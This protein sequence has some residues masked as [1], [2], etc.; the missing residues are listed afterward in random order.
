ML[1]WICKQAYNLFSRQPIRLAIVRRYQDANGNYV[2][3]LYMEQDISRKHDTLT[4]YT[5]I[6][7]S[8]DTL[9]IFADR[10]DAFH[11]SEFD[12]TL[13]TRNDFLAPMMSNVVRV[14]SLDPLANDSVRRMIA[15]L[16]RRNI[17]MTVQNKFIED[18]RPAGPLAFNLQTKTPEQIIQE[19]DKPC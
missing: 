5:M 4:G 15:R 8:L 10:L 6:G 9:P 2:G 14:G 19:F 13:D 12:W 11:F 7:V 3:E 16:P 1:Q 18:L 17:V